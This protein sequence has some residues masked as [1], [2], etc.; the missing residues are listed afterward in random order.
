MTQSLAVVLKI[1][2]AAPANRVGS[3]VMMIS[4]LEGIAQNRSRVMEYR[5]TG[6][7]G[8]EKG[9]ESNT[10]AQGFLIFCGFLNL[11]H[12]DLVHVLHPLVSIMVLSHETEG[13]TM[14]LR[15][16]FTVHLIGQKD[17]L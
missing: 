9:K 5:S 15:K 3:S 14:I 17:F 12:G 13:E 10:P 2:A 6:V 1:A 7:L 11:L 4:G 8:K 16:D